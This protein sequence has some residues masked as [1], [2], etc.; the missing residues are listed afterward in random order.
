MLLALRFFAVD[1]IVLAPLCFLLLFI[2][3]RNRANSNKDP[4]IRKLYYRGFYFK[5]FCVLAYTFV[6][7]F[8]FKGGGTGLY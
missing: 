8:V 5:V 4:F 2:I 7:E 3:V 6:T 1:D